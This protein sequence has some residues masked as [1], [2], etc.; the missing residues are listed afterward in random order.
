[1]IKKKETY[2]PEDIVWIEHQI[3]RSS[4]QR[5]VWASVGRI[6]FWILG[7]KGLRDIYMDLS[8]EDDCAQ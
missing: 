5:I 1:M 7:M 8:L 2:Q 6:N 3:L 4:Q